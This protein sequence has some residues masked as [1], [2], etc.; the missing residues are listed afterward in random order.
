MQRRYRPLNA[1]TRHCDGQICGVPWIVDG[2]NVI[3]SRPDGWW[4]DRPR[5]RRRLVERLAPLVAGGSAV[6]VVFDGAEGPDEVGAG[7]ALG[8]EVR[9][10]PGG[11][12]AAD[13]V[14]ARLAEELTNPTG[15]SVVT[16]DAG[17]RRRV[18]DAGVAV[19]SV[20]A[21]LERVTPPD[22][23]TPPA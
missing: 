16:S 4:R 2:M 19:V 18:R 11:P 3:G 10:A 20:S 5:A 14:I 12:D 6:T 9:F 1:G 15:W 22:R 8:V 21:F 13:D 7:A 17:L 23:P